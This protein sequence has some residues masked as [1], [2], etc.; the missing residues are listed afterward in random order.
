MAR[1]EDIIG[2]QGSLQRQY[3]IA[4]AIFLVLVLGIILLFGHLISRSLSRRYIEDV[5]VSGRQ[6]ARRIAEELGEQAAQDLE[7]LERRREQ[8]YRS[9]EGIL[10][11]QVYESIVVTDR[12]G[13]VVGRFETR[14]LEDLPDGMADDLEMSGAL[15]DEKI[16]ETETPYR[17]MVPLGD[18]VGEI[19]LNVSRARVNQRV[20]ALRRELLT[21][22]IAVAV[23]TLVTLLGAFVLVWLLVQ[24]TRRV[25]AKQHEAE[26]LAALGTLAAN[27]A[28]EIRN[29][30]NSINLNLELLD[31]DLGDHE[32]DA[33]SSLA[34]TRKEVGR[35]AKLVSD[36]L[37][38][39]RPGEPTLD[40]VSVP[41]MLGDVGD[42]LRAE[43]ASLGVHLKVVTGP[44]DVV[45]RADEGQLRQVVLNLVL[46]AIQAVAELE[47]NRRVV[48]L[49]AS[50][51]GDAV[52]IRVTDRGN[53]IEDAELARVREAFYTKRRGGS[54]LG[55]AIAQRFAEAHGGTIELEN[56]DTAGFEARIVLPVGDGAGKMSERPVAADRQ[57]G[58]RMNRQRLIGTVIAM[59]VA[60]PVF[61]GFG[62]AD[63]VYIPVASHSPGAVGS[64]WRTDLY[65]LNVSDVAIDV[66]VAYLPSGLI[67][68]TVV[69]VDRTTWL[70]GRDDDG[71]GRIN[72]SLAD[73]P[74]NGTVVIRDIV[75]E[76][77]VDSLGASG[78]GALVVFAYEADTLEDDGSRVFK[79]AVVNARIYNEATMWVEDPDSPGDFIEQPAEYGQTMPGVPWYNLADGGAVDDTTDFSFEQLTGGEEGG[80]LRYNV[81]VL[82]A[83][84]PQT[85]LTIAIQ[86]YQASGEPYR[87]ADDNEIVSII[88]MP[89]ASHVQLFR[90]FRDEWDLADTEG[91][92]VRVSIEA[93]SSLSPNPVPLI[94]S[95][96]SVIVN[97]TNDPS[98]VLPSFVYPYD[99]D[100]MWGGGGTV[101]R[102]RV[103]RRPVEMPPLV[104]D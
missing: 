2:T 8:I 9:F 34:V 50:R 36:F 71:F 63:L 12:E 28:H 55:L 70:G 65:V 68:N 64:Q 97:N 52:R 76:Y 98:T 30:L 5:L 91:A 40:T 49:G 57:G 101:K 15:P 96:G 73:I 21:Q 4:S 26:E 87:D 32:S 81:G 102:A 84:D 19:V 3:A 11:R 10:R 103:D 93:W 100:C 7:V 74:P 44:P 33:R 47:A 77:W 29:P 24:R 27:L 79:D 14:S 1:L 66:A 23:L 92:T 35:L 39:A 75:G 51:V 31:E 6:D 95:Y 56:L 42:F 54:G 43:A 53:G 17:I 72:Q 78:N 20:G 89:P 38:Y 16:T 104:A 82:N 69:F 61:A 22:T 86:P 25:E 45:V 13:R 59:L 94:T 67:S 90:P 80:G 83:S 18:D 85:T 48:E 60:G 58:S 41:A 46:N 37:T 88:T 62:A 99:V